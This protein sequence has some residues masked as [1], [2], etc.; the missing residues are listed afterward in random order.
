[1]D[2]ENH[3]LRINVKKYFVHLSTQ[4]EISSRIARQASFFIRYSLVPLYC[5]GQYAMILSSHL[6]SKMNN[7]LLSMCL[8]FPYFFLS[9][10]Y[11]QGGA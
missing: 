2:S 7:T 5:L 4:Y 8:F 1:M 9:K 11:T 6:S 3:I 10:L